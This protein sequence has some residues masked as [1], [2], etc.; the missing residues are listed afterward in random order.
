MSCHYARVFKAREQRARARLSPRATRSASI[1]L[2]YIEC[3]QGGAQRE[4]YGARAIIAQP[5]TP[6]AGDAQ[7]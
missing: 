2:L 5:P 3:A 4:V 1:R 7:T 6:R